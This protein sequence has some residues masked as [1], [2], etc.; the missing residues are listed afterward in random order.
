MK[1]YVTGIFSKQEDNSRIRYKNLL[2]GRSNST[3]SRLSE[4]IWII[5]FFMDWPCRIELPERKNQMWRNNLLHNSLSQFLSL[6]NTSDWDFD[7]H[8]TNYWSVNLSCKHVWTGPK[9]LS[10]TVNGGFTWNEKW[11]TCD[12]SR[13]YN[14]KKYLLVHWITPCSFHLE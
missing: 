1:I 5:L 12:Q 9:L 11:K 7:Q 14:Q 13:E 10:L 2:K 6:W 8:I 4:R 3:W